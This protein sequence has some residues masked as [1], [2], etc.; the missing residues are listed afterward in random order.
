M[1]YGTDIEPWFDKQDAVYL[2]G[3][4]GPYRQG[5]VC[6]VFLN[7]AIDKALPLSIFEVINGAKPKSPGRVLPLPLEH[8]YLRNS[9]G[10]AFP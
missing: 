10:D 8:V 3:R 2:R 1:G 7:S 6:D 5:Y 9:G 4:L